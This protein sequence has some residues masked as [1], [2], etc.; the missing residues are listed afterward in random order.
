MDRRPRLII[1]ASLLSLLILLIT[2]FPPHQFAIAAQPSSEPQLAPQATLS[3]TTPNTPSG[4]HIFLPII[5]SSGHGTTPT[6]RPPVAGSCAL[7]LPANTT[8]TI[9]LQTAASDAD[10]DTLFWSLNGTPAHGKATINGSI[11]SYTPAADYTGPD[12]VRYT[13]SDGRGGTTN[14]IVTITVQPGTPTGNQPPTVTLEATVLAGTFP[15][16]V[17]FTATAS[18]ANGDALTYAWDFGDGSEGGNQATLTHVYSRTGLFEARVTV[19][20]AASKGSDAVEVRVKSRPGDPPDPIDSA[21]PVDPT[22]ADL[23]DLLDQ[24]HLYRPIAGADRRRTRHDRS[25]AGGGGAWT[26]DHPRRRTVGP[27]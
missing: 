13:L 1:F 9:D 10:G 20:D 25:R 19:R 12:T 21:P 18:D 14:G 7:L 4:Q 17:G 16:S 27:A 22:R 6:N 23:G 15:L 26:S 11:L 2:A 3:C 5:R 24:I 8:A